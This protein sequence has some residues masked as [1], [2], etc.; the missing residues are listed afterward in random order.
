MGE[1]FKISRPGTYRLRDGRSIFVDIV[2]SCQTH[3]QQPQPISAVLDG[4]RRYWYDNGTFLLGESVI[5]IVA[6]PLDEP[7]S[8]GL[9][10][11]VTICEGMLGGRYATIDDKAPTTINFPAT[12]VIDLRKVLASAIV[13]PQPKSEKRKVWIAIKQDG[14]IEAF[15]FKPAHRMHDSVAFV[16]TEI[17]FT[18]GEGL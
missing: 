16:E 4:I 7:E 1:T 15:K 14:W 8:A 12:H 5:D 13:K 9:T 3:C 10:G 6:G 17:E 18:C 11:Y 2:D